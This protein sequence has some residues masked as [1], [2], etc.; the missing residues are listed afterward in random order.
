LHSDP[1]FPD[2][3]PGETQRVRGRLSFYEGQQI[4]DEFRRIDSTGWRKP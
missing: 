3:S 2:C 1:K 4:E